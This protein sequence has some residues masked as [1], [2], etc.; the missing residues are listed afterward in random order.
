VDA[1]YYKFPDEKYLSGLVAQVPEDFQFGFKVTDEMFPNLPH[2]PPRRP[3]QR[4]L[5]QRR[6]VREW[7]SQ[8]MRALPPEHRVADV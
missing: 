1:V 6:P 2:P 7:I 3:G 5:S 4:T 8:T